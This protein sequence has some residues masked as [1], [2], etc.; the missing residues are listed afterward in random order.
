MRTNIIIWD[1]GLGSGHANSTT[2]L[3]GPLAARVLREHHNVRV[4][5]RSST[6]VEHAVDEKHDYPAKA[7]LRGEFLR[8]ATEEPS[9]SGIPGMLAQVFWDEKVVDI[10]PQ[11]N[12]VVLSSGEE[13]QADL[14]IAADGIKSAIRPHVVGDAAFQT[15]RP[16]SL[17][18]FRF[19]LELGDIKMPL[20]KVPPILP[21]DQPTCL[22]IVY[23]FGDTMRSVVMYPCRNFA[24]LNF[25]CIVPDSS[26]K[27]RSSVSGFS[28]MGIGVRGRTVLV[29]DAAHAMTPHQGQGGTK[30][31]EDVEVFR[32]FFGASAAAA[33]ATILPSD[34]QP[35]LKPMH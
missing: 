30:A 16:S 3:A 25:V 10:S 35:A 11:E 22:S 18:A 19:T 6:P 4:Y 17:S 9:K 14:I 29:G 1:L 12:R 8:L 21:S 20:K 28:D 33:S 23:S 2:R 26:L 5:E 34:P 27:K 7:D 24:I 15:A 31:V 32:L 13:I